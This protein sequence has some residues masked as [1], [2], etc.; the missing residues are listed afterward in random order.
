[1][2]VQAFRKPNQDHSAVSPCRSFA[3]NRIKCDVL[4]AARPSHV[5]EALIE[6][7]T[8]CDAAAGHWQ[9]HVVQTVVETYPNESLQ[10]ARQAQIVQ[11]L[12]EVYSE[13]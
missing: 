12:V 4:K 3:G 2:H 5:L 10:A 7:I 11:S 9:A 8:K 6:V 1:M 13:T